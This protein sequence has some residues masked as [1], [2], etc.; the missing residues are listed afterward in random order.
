MAKVNLGFDEEKLLGVINAVRDNP[1]VGKTVWK[2][3]SHWNQ[4]FQSEARITGPDGT[5]HTVPMDEPEAMGGGGTAPNMVEQV[6][7]AYGCCLITGYVAQAGLRGVELKGVDIEVEGD[8]DL[9]GFFGLSEEVSPG[10]SEVR[11]KIS[12]DAPGA[13]PEQIK[14]IHDAVHATS[15][16]GNILT[17]PVSVKAELV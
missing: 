2:A 4:G 9:R 13:T 5:T 7:G 11:A 3:A 12:L 15:P 8:L 6:L 17:R 1:E 14:E 10:Y 16:V